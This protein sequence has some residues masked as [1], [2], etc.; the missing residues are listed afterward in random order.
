MKAE[1]ARTLAALYSH[2]ATAPGTE[3][4]AALIAALI[5]LVRDDDQPTVESPMCTAN[6]Y[7]MTAFHFAVQRGWTAVVEAM[8]DKLA[9]APDHLAQL[10]APA[11][12]GLSPIMLAALEGNAPMLQLL[13][14]RTCT[15]ADAGATVNRPLMLNGWTALHYAAAAVDH[16]VATVAALAKLPGVNLGAR[17]WHST[18][19]GDIAREWDPALLRSSG[20][21]SGSSKLGVSQGSTGSSNGSAA[22]PYASPS[23]SLSMSLSASQDQSNWLSATLTSSAFQIDAA[24]P[25]SPLLARIPAMPAAAEPMSSTSSPSSSGASRLLRVAAVASNLPRQHPFWDVLRRQDP[26][27][28]KAVL[29]LPPFAEAMVGSSSGDPATDLILSPPPLLA[30]QGSSAD[31]S[32]T[33]SVADPAS[34]SA[35]LNTSASSKSSGGRSGSAFQWLRKLTV[36]RP[37]TAGDA[38]ALAGDASSSLPPSPSAS[39]PPGPGLAASSGGGMLG[40]I[41]GSMDPASSPTDPYEPVRAA[42]L[43]RL[44]E[45]GL[46]TA[47]VKPAGPGM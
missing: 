28:L 32:S 37:T 14:A 17:T 35:A 38:E 1:L 18:S 46:E 22:S 39:Y 31:M 6:E 45:L 23:V 12:R 24:L 29:A 27:D 47:V 33:G 40:Q 25:K 5:Q 9:A 11:A 10:C 41:Y 7:G 36:K 44:R 30:Q 13:L 15:P 42:N 21:T 26:V 4:P 2:H 3:P 43:Q 34:V 8:L 20:G 16:P 19:P